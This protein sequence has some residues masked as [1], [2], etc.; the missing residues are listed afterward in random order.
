MRGFNA[1]RE[2]RLSQTGGLLLGRGEYLFPGTIDLGPLEFVT[3]AWRLN[4]GSRTKRH[5]HGLFAGLVVRHAIGVVLDANV[6]L[7][8][9]LDFAIVD[10]HGQLSQYRVGRRSARWGRW[11]DGGGSHDG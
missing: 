4:V 10:R 6:S 11:S 8:R 2:E 5:I 3:F 9:S 1:H 7:T